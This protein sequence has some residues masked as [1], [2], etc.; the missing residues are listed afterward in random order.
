MT[1]TSINLRAF[2][3]N[4]DLHQSWEAELVAQF[5]DWVV[6]RSPYGTHAEHHSKCLSYAMTHSNLGIF[7]TREYYNV[8]IDFT[9]DGQFKMLYINVATPA[10]LRA[11]ELSWRDLYLDVVR[12]PGKPA[13]LVDQDEFQVARD[14]ALLTVELATKTEVVAYELMGK[15]DQGAFPFLVTEYDKTMQI[16]TDPSISISVHKERHESD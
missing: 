9:A 14:A 7:N 13:E 11:H 2:K 8:F 15:V 1:M 5:G 6:I 16:I 3:P 12:L 4:G 10:I